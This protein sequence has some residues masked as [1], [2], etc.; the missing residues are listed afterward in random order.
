M[1]G[2]GVGETEASGLG[3]DG[4]GA[5]SGPDNTRE[6][7]P[8]GARSWLSSEGERR[9]QDGGGVW[10]ICVWAQLP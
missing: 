10:G 8:L 1:R 5:A 2:T 4:M 3:L 6:V 7:P 9:R